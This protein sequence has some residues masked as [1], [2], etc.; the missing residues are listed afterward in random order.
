MPL[1]KKIAVLPALALAATAGAAG[2]QAPAAGNPLV[3]RVVECRA[4][5]DV[6]A[7]VRCYDEAVDALAKATTSGDIVVVDREDVRSTRRS[8][9]G[10]SLPRLPLFRGDSTAEEEAPEEIEAKIAS[11]RGLGYGKYLIVLDSGARW[12]TTEPPRGAAPDPQ[13]GEA[14]RISKGALGAYF[15]SV[16]GRRAVKGMRVG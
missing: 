1:L 11:V 4:M 3:A 6:P 2:A 9:F 5:A 16:D 8:L 12:Q 7:R 14:I 13:P 15:L 10:F